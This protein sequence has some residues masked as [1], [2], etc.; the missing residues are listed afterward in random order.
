[1]RD[2][3]HRRAETNRE[4]SETSEPRLPAETSRKQSGKILNPLCSTN[5]EQRGPS[6][7]RAKLLQAGR[8]TLKSGRSVQQPFMFHYG[9]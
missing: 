2:L 6:V 8:F 9:E 1:M 7:K 3:Q 5:V 4:L